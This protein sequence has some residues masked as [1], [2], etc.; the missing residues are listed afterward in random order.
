VVP[1]RFTSAQLNEVRDILLA[2]WREWRIETFG[3]SADA[4]AQPV[5]TAKPFRVTAEMADWADSL[6]AGLLRLNPALAPA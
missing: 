1:S 2:R 6:P 4:Q 3:T 5:I